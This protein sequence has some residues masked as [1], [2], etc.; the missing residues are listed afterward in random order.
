MT[1]V[2]VLILHPEPGDRA[3]GIETWVA[4]AR[5]ALAERHRV[6]FVAAGATDA[7]IVGGPTDGRSFGERLRAFLAERRPDGVVVLGSGAIPFADVADRRTFVA[8]AG[9]P[10]RAALANNRY[11]ADVIAVSDVRS[12]PA[13]PDLPSD[14]ALPRWL[15]EWAGWAVDDRR[16][17]WRLGFDI[18]G[19]LDLVLMGSRS[20]LPRPPAGLIER[21][22]ARLADVARVTADPG[23]ELVVAGRTSAASLAWLERSIAARTRAFVE[24]RG[25]RTAVEG[26]RPPRSLLGELLESGAGGGLGAILAGLGDAGLVDSRVLIAHG[27]GADESGWPPA[28]DRFASDL[29]LHE[30]IGDPWLRD[31]T[32]DAADARIPILLGGHSLVGPGLRLVPGAADRWT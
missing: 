30:R 7:T 22:V 4:A 10:G 2:A 29:L 31:L 5:R 1:E 27:R 17:S 16:R 25:M 26:Q 11:S 14:N 20:W 23:L 9:A 24:E 8:A 12:L 19:P 15:A 3:G 32:R 18:D 28:G 21:V 6:G 13:L